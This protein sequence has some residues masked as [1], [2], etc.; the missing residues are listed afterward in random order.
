MKTN[1]P[2]SQTKTPRKDKLMEKT[3]LELKRRSAKALRQAK[4]ELLTINIETQKGKQALAHYAANWNDLTH[5]GIL[6]LACEAAGGKPDDAA[7]MQVILL[8]LTA[9]IDIHDDIIDKTL[10]K[11]GKPTVLGM[12]GKETALL[13]GNAI[14][15]KG[16]LLLCKNGRTLSK[17]T[18]NQLTDTIQNTFFDMGN[19]HLLEAEM[20]K[21]RELNP[22]AYLRIIEKKASNIEA[23]TRIGAIIGNGSEKE[24]KTLGK[25]GKILGTLITLR[26]EFIDIY[27]PEELYN[28]MKN[29]SPPLPLLYAFRNPKAKER[30]EKLLSS[31]ELSQDATDE[32]VD[33]IHKSREVAELKQKMQKL[34]EEA[35][36]VIS[37]TPQ[38]RLALKLQQV[39]YSTL[40]DL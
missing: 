36:S 24:V 28:R 11:N 23:I 25:Y 10:T 14:F 5:P 39:A 40:E 17:E 12:A 31:E 15:M 13:I 22:E 4:K 16:F 3:L 37:D 32:I 7:N 29:Q 18:S 35:I 30:I 38:K 9:A 1:E 20:R 6:S 27:E 21:K 19:A 34:Y 26:E 2:Q 8:L 33:T